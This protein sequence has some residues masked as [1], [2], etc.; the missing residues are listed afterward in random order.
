MSHIFMK[1]ITLSLFITTSIAFGMEEA[2]QQPKELGYFSK[3]PRDLK[4]KVLINQFNDLLAKHRNEILTLQGNLETLKVKASEAFDF[5]FKTNLLDTLEDR[6]KDLNI[7][8]DQ[9]IQLLLNRIKELR[10][11]NNGNND[12]IETIDSKEFKQEIE[13]I[14]NSLKQKKIDTRYDDYKSTSPIDWSILGK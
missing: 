11:S 4:I 5:N 2:K 12:F 3:L 6:R 10:E 8:I 1:L 14:L 9:S 13:S 7:K